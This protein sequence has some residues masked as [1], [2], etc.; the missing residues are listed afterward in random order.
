M[1][2]ARDFYD[3]LIKADLDFFSGVPDSLLKD[4]CA[5]ITMSAPPERHIIAANEGN[6]IG[7]ACGYHMSTGKYGVAYM[8]NSGE[9]NAV[10]PL[11]S[12]ADPEVY[13]IPML[14]LIGWRGMP[15]EHDEPQ[16]VKQGRITCDLLDA[17]EIPYEILD[18]DW[19]PQLKRCVDIMKTQ[20]RPVALVI[21]K[22]AF[23]SYPFGP[24]D[25]GAM[26]TREQALEVLLDGLSDDDFTVSTTGKTSR[27][28]FEI[29]E[30]QNQDHAHDF[31]TVGSMG[32]TSS[33]AF[34]MAIGTEAN[35][36]CI[37]GDGSFLMHMG[38][39]P[40]IAQNAPDNF[41]YVLNING[42]HESVGGQPTVAERIDIPAILKAC[43]FINVIEAA[44]ADEI[45]KGVEVVRQNPKS[46]LVITTRQGSRK[47]LGRPTTTPK[48]NKDALIAK[49][50][51]YRLDTL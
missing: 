15:G 42:A 6:A 3:G 19:Q 7:M 38:A 22:G 18:A 30:A 20:S 29:R 45:K 39:F 47:D 4:L 34:G 5:C 35:V 43:G 27:E 11:L 51:S 14:L 31:L 23:S 37:D 36:W 13:S 12:L 1:I 16:H 28:I 48:E 50:Q 46:A 8:Q 10:N 21:K 49:L 40:V 33:I 25:N 44:T 41:K 17:M 32:H 2:D 24:E 26:L 9:G